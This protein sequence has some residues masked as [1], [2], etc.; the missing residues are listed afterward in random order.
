[1]TF[2]KNVI[3]VAGLP[4]GM[5][6]THS[7][8][9]LAL[10]GNSI[11]S[12]TIIVTFEDDSTAELTVSVIDYEVTL[13][14]QSSENAVWNYTWND[15]P[16][17]DGENNYYY[18]VAEKEVPEDYTVSYNRSSTSSGHKTIV[19]N[20]LPTELKVSKLWQDVN[21]NVIIT[22]P[23]TE[24][25]D[26]MMAASLPDSI[27]IQLYQKLK[28]ETSTPVDISMPGEDADITTQFS[29][30]LYGT[31]TLKKSDGYQL[32]IP[33]LPETNLQGVEFVYYVKEAGT[34]LLENNAAYYTLSGDSNK[35][36]NAVTYEHNG[37]LAADSGTVI[38][39]N[40]VRTVD[41][42]IKKIWMMM[43]TIPR[44]Y[45]STCTS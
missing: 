9:R 3:S 1:M 27:Q 7:E 6:E 14:K 24:G 38:I 21:G 23:E 18:Y 11:S 33:E 19:T 2:D 22:D 5:T 36:I 13:G 39:R 15:L 4:E 12:G 8:T 28:D 26:Q 30:V 31:Y 42:N 43:R 35:Y 25:Y 16:F 40:T 45:Y 34:H 41:L 37:Q 44:H 20:S 10:S 17:S 29:G 32:S